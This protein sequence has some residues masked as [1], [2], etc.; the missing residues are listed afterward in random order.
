MIYQAIGIDLRRLGI[1]LVPFLGGSAASRYHE[2]I[3]DEKMASRNLW[4]KDISVGFCRAMKPHG[5]HIKKKE[6]SH[7]S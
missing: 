6:G 5:N 2:N 7:F 1:Q 3:Y 4:A